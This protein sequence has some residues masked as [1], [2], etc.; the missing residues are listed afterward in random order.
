MEDKLQTVYVRKNK[1]KNLLLDLKK[2]SGYFFTPEELNKR[3]R[4]VAEKAYAEGFCRA[5]GLT[6]ST[7]SKDKYLNTNYP[8]L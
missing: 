7:L 6:E 4:E 5:S 3:D 2:K 1:S 8:I